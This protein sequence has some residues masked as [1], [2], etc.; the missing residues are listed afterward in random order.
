[1]RTGAFSAG[2]KVFGRPGIN[3]LLLRLLFL[4]GGL[5]AFWSLQWEWLQLGV[6]Q[7]LVVIFRI[8]NLPVTTSAVR[9][10]PLLI[11]DYSHVFAVTNFCTY[12]DLILITLPFCW[13]FRKP[14]IVNVLRLLIAAAFI[15]FMNV[16][17]IVLALY[18]H[19]KG[20]SWTLAHHLPHNLIFMG[21]PAISVIFSLKSDCFSGEKSKRSVL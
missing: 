6:R 19:R 2:S 13:R 4:A 1:M 5:A 8:F 3:H 16:W 10:V 14:V 7:I 21:I 20:V 15:S 11:L 12:A 9:G 17:R 18:L